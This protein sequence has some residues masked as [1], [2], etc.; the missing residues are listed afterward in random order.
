M[1]TKAENDVVAE[2]PA[3]ERASYRDA[4]DRV[5]SD[6]EGVAG[7]KWGLQ[8]LDDI[9]LSAA[10]GRCLTPTNSFGGACV[11]V[12]MSTFENVV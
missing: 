12:A 11:V 10:A 2:L 4:R 3:V 6:E 9:D 5:G 8:G 7:T 1:I